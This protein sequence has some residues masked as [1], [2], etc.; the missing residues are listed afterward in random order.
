VIVGEMDVRRIAV[1]A[2]GGASFLW[3][4]SNVFINDIGRSWRL[5]DKLPEGRFL[6]WL[7]NIGVLRAKGQNEKFP[8]MLYVEVGLFALSCISIA[9]GIVNLVSAIMWYKFLRVLFSDFI[10]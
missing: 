8:P 5:L 4:V 10:Q 9:L 3:L 1:V 6:R 7:F 2:V